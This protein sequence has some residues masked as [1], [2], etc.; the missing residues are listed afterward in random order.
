MFYL[1]THSTHFIYGYLASDIWLGN[2]LPPFQSVRTLLYAPS[3]I[4]DRWRERMMSVWLD[5]WMMDS[6]MDGYR[7]W[8]YGWMNKWSIQTW[9]D[10]GIGYTAGWMNDE[11]KQWMNTGI[12]YTAEWMNDEFKHGWIRGLGI[13]LDEWM[14]DSN[15]D[16]YRDWV[17][18]WMN[19]WWFQIWMNTGIGYTAE[20]M[21]DEF[22]HGWIRGL[23]IR[24]DEWMIISSMMDSDEWF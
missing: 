16:G 12:G 15:M 20:W 23:G 14:M 13:R 21:N 6:N 1:T 4:Q 2:P 17:Y 7:D 24:L 10:T 3:H 11:F 19:E 22:K 5:E 8:V 9:M 18:G